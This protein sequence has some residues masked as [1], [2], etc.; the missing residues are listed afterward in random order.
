MSEL[1]I[2]NTLSGKL[3]SFEPKVEGEVSMYVCGPT[4]YDKGHLGHGRS[5]VSFDMIR[6]YLEFK[7]YKV[8]F[9]TNF[10]DIDDK[11]INRAKEEGISVKELA[12]KIIPLYERDF[13][14]LKILRPTLRP[15]STDPENIERMQIM[16]DKLIKLDIAYEIEGDGIYFDVSKYKD[17]GQLSKQK[18][19]ELQHGSRIAVKDEKRTPHDFVLWKYKKDGEPSW[20]D[21]AG[22]I[23]EGRPGWHIEC[24]AMAFEALGETFDIHAGGQDLTFPHHECEIAQ[25]C[26][27]TGH[28]HMCNFWLHNGFVNIDGEKMS[29]SLNNFTTLEDTFKSYSPLVVRYL[30]L[31]IHYRAP[32]DFNDDSLEQAKASRNRIQEFYERVNSV[33]VVD[34]NIETEE[35]RI[36]RLERYDKY[37]IEG[38]DDDF[39]V[40]KAISTVFD[41]LKEINAKIDERANDL[42]SFFPNVKSTYLFSSEKEQILE[43]L[44][45]F[46]KIFQVIETEKREFSPEIVD[47]I[48]QRKVARENRDFALSDKLRDQLLE[49]GVESK[50]GADGSRYSYR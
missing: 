2:Y 25:T 40:S 46:N 3:E 9:V 1:K 39:N 33:P 48:E 37:F 10:T 24:S 31:S 14:A 44:N 7:G 4:V 41:L 19:D 26:C 27:Y 16:I 12:D 47:L 49:F 36:K 20:T 42:N 29:K 34:D 23:P 35:I 32:I 18:L 8:K 22:V 21:P 17:Y 38:M 30:L 15:L 50:D 28:D 13:D 6:R 11:M 5:M 45:N 43:F